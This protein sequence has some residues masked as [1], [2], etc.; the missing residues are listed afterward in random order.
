MSC[1]VYLY[2]LKN[3]KCWST[4]ITKHEAHDAKQLCVETAV[5]QAKQETAEQCQVHADSRGNTS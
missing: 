5:T 1:C 3:S 4:V 2:K